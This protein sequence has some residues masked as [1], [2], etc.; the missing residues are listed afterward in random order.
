MPA[1]LLDRLRE[2]DAQPEP[3]FAV[4]GTVNWMRALAILV[5]SPAFSNEGLAKFYSAIVRRDPNR[6]ADTAAF[7]RLLMA[8]HNAAAVA[9]MNASIPNRYNVVRSQIVSWYYAIYGAASAMVLGASGSRTEQHTK[10]ARIWHADIAVKGAAPGPFGLALNTVV[11]SQVKARVDEFRDGCNATLQTTPTNRHEAWG[12]ACA[13]LSGTADFQR[14]HLEAKLRKEPA[15]KN[16]GVTNFQTTAARCLRDV[17]LGK[18]RVNFVAQA[19]RYRGKA[20]YRDSV[21][22][23]YGNDYGAALNRFAEDLESVANAFVRIASA[24][25]RVR[26]EDGVWPQF[27]TDLRQNLRVS[28][29]LSAVGI[30]V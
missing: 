6:E 30:V 21:Y 22:L 24:Y 19:F 7:E 8:V 27:V 14:T 18:G 25:L 2:T 10:L 23:S 13:Y 20:N 4:Q 3:R 11:P 26:V 28:C 5:D 16:L 15:F 12:A 9:S 29:D 17:A 1:W